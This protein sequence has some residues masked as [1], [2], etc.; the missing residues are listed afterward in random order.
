MENDA[1]HKDVAI[2]E[3]NN[4]IDRFTDNKRLWSVIIVAFFNEGLKNK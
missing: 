1:F 4:L 3:R 2:L